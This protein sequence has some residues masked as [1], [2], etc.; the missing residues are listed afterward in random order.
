MLRAKGLSAALL[1]LVL[2]GAAAPA[3]AETTKVREN[4]RLISMLQGEQVRRHG[5]HPPS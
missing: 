5:W 1:T 2:A 3:Q 4:D